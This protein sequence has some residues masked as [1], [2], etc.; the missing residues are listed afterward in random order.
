[1]KIRAESNNGF[2]QRFLLI[3]IVC[4]GF[5]FYCLYDGFIAYPAELAR[6]TAFYELE[7]S[8]DDETSGDSFEVQ[9]EALAAEKAWSIDK[10]K[11]KPA[12]IQSDII[13]QYGM[14]A[15]AFMV[16]LPVLFNF[17]KT[18]NSWLESD[19]HEVTTSWGQSMQLDQV[20]AVDKKKWQKKGIAK[21]TYQSN[22]QRAGLVMDDFK[23]ER[24]PI[25]EMLSQIESKLDRH[26]ITG[27]PTQQELADFEEELAKAEAEPPGSVEE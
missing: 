17:L 8:I 3:S 24:E 22:G 21:I 23:Y 4:L 20:E 1:M 13:W 11:K 5:G 19:G 16:G 10:P 25:G 2:L 12:I 15:I 26:Q 6:S 27:G 18:R 7:K 14:A 9:W